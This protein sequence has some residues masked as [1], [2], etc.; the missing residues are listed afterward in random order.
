MKKMEFSFVMGLMKQH[1]VYMTFFLFQ[2]SYLHFSL[3]RLVKLAKMKKSKKHVF[4]ILVK[5]SEKIV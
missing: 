1:L 5:K 3:V 4:S 2:I